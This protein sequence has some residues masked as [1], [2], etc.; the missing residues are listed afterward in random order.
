MLEPPEWS[1]FIRLTAGAEPWPRLVQAAELLGRPGD[2]LDLGC[3]AGRDTGYLLRHDFRVVAVDSSPL[4]GRAVKRLPHQ[5]NLH[6]VECA[7]E[8]FGYA[9]YDLIN[10]QFVL[11]FVRRERFSG[12]V[13][14]M[15]A[16]VRPG[17]VLAATFFGPNDE[18]NEPGSAVNFVTRDE[19]P[20]LLEPLVIVD[21][22]EEDRD[23]QTANGTPK[24]W[25]A[26]HVLAQRPA[27]P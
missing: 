15:V 3:G 10:A 8:D 4:A 11:P 6:F 9:D 23:G 16:A 1:E 19:V 17:G 22:E 7:I 13:R 24:H 18:W 20:S 12:C 2:A 26:F 25:H 21:L 27:G 5:R 14:E